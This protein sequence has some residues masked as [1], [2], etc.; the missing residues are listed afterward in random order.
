MAPHARYLNRNKANGSV[1]PRESLKDI[2]EGS[3]K[4]LYTQIAINNKEE[5]RQKMKEFVMM[6]YERLD[7]AEKVF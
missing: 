7:Y 5:E 3:R 1:S 6:E 4:M 2:V